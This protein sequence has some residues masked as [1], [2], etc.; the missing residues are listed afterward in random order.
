MHSTLE[1]LGP[2]LFF[3]FMALI[4]LVAQIV[5][6]AQEWERGVV[7]RLGKFDRTRGPGLFF[8]IPFVEKVIKVDI[9]V[10]AHEVPPQEVIT[11]DNVTI[12]VSAVIY[13]R[14][15]A[16]SVE[17]AVC[18]VFS[19]YEATSQIAQTTLRSILG[20]HELD[21]LLAHRDKINLALQKII[22]EQTGPWGVKVS[23][24]EIKDV[25]LPASM[26]RAMARQAEAEREKRAKIIHADGEFQASQKLA[27]AA[28]VL[29]RHTSALQLRFLQTLTEISAEKNSTIIFPVPIDTLMPFLDRVRTDHPTAAP[30]S[31]PAPA[32][33]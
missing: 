6:I 2:L 17:N 28:D 1:V 12:K 25:E 21:D 14:V 16:E 9:R 23:A 5:K 3:G 7:L 10:V 32:A 31:G 20:Q 24:V 19:Y 33:G 30:T 26:Q 15:L 11:R 29:S 4:T 8:L 13:F 27:D 22:D 18:R